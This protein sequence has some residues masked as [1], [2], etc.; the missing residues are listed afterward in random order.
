MINGNWRWGLGDGKWRYELGDESE[1]WRWEMGGG[2][3]RWP[4]ICTCCWIETF[5]HPWLAT[6]WIEAFFHSGSRRL[7][8]K[9]NRNSALYNLGRGICT[10]WLPLS[11]QNCFLVFAV[12]WGMVKGEWGMQAGC[13]CLVVCA[14]RGGRTDGREGCV[15]ESGVLGLSF[16]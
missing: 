6:T 7:W 4:T 14:S 2:G 12:G 11:F 1:R 10:T 13:W 8:S 16:I 3:N 5:Y 15:S 9:H